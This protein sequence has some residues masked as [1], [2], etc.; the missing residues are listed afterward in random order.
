VPF[1]IAHTQGRLV[2]KLEGAV[3]VR[4]AQDLA[5]RVAEEM[6]EGAAVSVDAGSL[7]DIDTC[8]LQ[9]LYSLRK[10]A[11]KLSFDNLSDAFIAAADRC[12]LRR[13]LLSARGNS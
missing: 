7:V 9:L 8:I 2:L 3:T 5:T 1:S 10:T 6:E 12:G 11:P 13:E 4:D